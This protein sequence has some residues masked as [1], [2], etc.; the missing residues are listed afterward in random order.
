MAH[1]LKNWG[2]GANFSARMLTEI[3]DLSDSAR[4]SKVNLDLERKPVDLV[5]IC[6]EALSHYE[7]AAGGKGIEIRA[8]LPDSPVIVETDRTAML[9]I[10]DNLLSNA[11]KFSPP[12]TLVS[13]SLGIAAVS[14][15]VEDAGP[16]FSEEDHK[17][18]FEPFTRLTARPIAGE[19][20]TG[21][22]L[23]VVKQLADS[24]GIS[25]KI[26]NA[27]RGARVTLDFESNSAFE[28]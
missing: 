24:L 10:V 26:D 25:I 23:A 27:A 2:G 28:E 12:E 11:V 16:G 1:D 6:R 8:R 4:A 17:N 14:I 19:V 9:R 18:L 15:V 3:A 20:S 5:R 7:A 22:G 13:L 21:L